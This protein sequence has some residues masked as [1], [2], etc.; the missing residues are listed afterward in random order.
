MTDEHHFTGGARDFD[1]WIGRWNVHNRFLKERLADTDEW[2]EFKSTV[3]ARPILG[4]FGNEDEFH[5]DHDGGYIAMSFR[6][7]DPVK[8][9]WSIYQLRDAVG[10][11][12]LVVLL[13]EILDRR[14][15]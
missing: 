6:F 4:G 3:V 9:R 10:R 1:F 7:F 2:D 8:K 5:I 12:P 11:P 14:A 15:V 13:L